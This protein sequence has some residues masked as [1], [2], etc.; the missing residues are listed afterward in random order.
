MNH[1]D[2]ILIVGASGRAAAASALR[3]GIN[4]GASIT[5]PIAIFGRSV[6]GRSR[7]D[8]GGPSRRTGTGGSRLPPVPGSTPVRWRITPTG[9]SGSRGPIA[10]LVIRPRCCAQVRNPFRVAE[11]LGRTGFESGR[12]P[13]DSVGLPRDGTWLVKPVASG[14]GRS[15][16]RLDLD[17]DLPPERA[18]SRD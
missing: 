6:P 1:V 9:L 16:Q 5:S 18:T 11:T 8:R 7:P 10:C 4:P 3:A 13:P 14:G 12:G 2:R 17:T 15:I